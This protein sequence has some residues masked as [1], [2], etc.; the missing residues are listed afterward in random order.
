MVKRTKTKDLNIVWLIKSTCETVVWIFR[1]H[2]FTKQTSSGDGLVYSVIGSI[3][4]HFLLSAIVYKSCFTFLS[5]KRERR[6]NGRTNGLVYLEKRNGERGIIGNF[7]GQKM[8]YVRI[9]GDINIFNIID[10]AWTALCQKTGTGAEL[11]TPKNV[12]HAVPAGLSYDNGW[13]SLYWRQYWKL[14]DLCLY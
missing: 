13:T 11:N 2:P 10:N 3:N 6:S 14:Q 1:F 5:T 7:V 9:T 12:V 8:V 4:F